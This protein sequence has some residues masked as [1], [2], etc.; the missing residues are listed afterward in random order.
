LILAPK[1]AAS[2]RIDFAAV[3]GQLLNGFKD[4]VG[5]DIDEEWEKI[6]RETRAATRWPIHGSPPIRFSANLAQAYT[7]GQIIM[8]KDGYVGRAIS[9]LVEAGDLIC[10]LLGYAMPMVLH[11][12]KDHFEVR[13]EIYVPG[14]MHGEAITALNAGERTLRDFELY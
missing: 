11:L 13:G 5:K 7:R 8:T 2:T 12:V 6:Q 1:G 9:P 10:V 14:I 4:W 3:A